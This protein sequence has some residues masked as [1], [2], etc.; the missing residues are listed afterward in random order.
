[1]K[2]PAGSQGKTLETRPQAS[3]RLR[4]AALTW[5]LLLLVSMAIPSPV[6]ATDSPGIQT[7]YMA[8][9]LLANG[10]VS[11]AYEYYQA[12]YADLLPEGK[13]ESLKKTLERLMS[14]S[15]T[16][17]SETLNASYRRAYLR[18]W[19]ELEKT[20]PPAGK[21]DGKSLKPA[22]SLPEPGAP[23][24]S[25]GPGDEDSD[26]KLKV[27]IYYGDYRPD[28]S[29]RTLKVS[30]KAAFQSDRDRFIEDAMLKA[31]RDYAERK[32][33][34]VDRFGQDNYKMVSIQHTVYKVYDSKWG[35]V[36][37]TN[38]ETS[39]SGHRER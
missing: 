38:S 5:L 3:G 33:Y 32:G 16:M 21:A 28:E 14:I 34:P 23:V 17:K 10:Q 39:G 9:G 18:L 11:K 26:L 29:I 15:A 19:P 2:N 4:S 30:E 24:N 37:A 27:L 22:V 35:N 36:L 20:L 1:M 6:Q 25:K 8:E 7:F 13:S 12:A 31:K